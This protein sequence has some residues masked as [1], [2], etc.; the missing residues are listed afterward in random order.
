MLA[1]EEMELSLRDGNEREKMSYAP[2]HPKATRDLVGRSHP[3]H[4]RRFQ[5]LQTDNEHSMNA[6][7]SKTR[8]NRQNTL[9][10]GSASNRD[11]SWRAATRRRIAGDAWKNG[12]AVRS[13]W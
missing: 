7:S 13:A 1:Q 6:M 10:V 4:A 12:L 8:K 3:I 11:Q 5:F 2:N 9:D